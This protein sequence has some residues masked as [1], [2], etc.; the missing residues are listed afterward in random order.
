[1]RRVC[2]LKGHF[3]FC[4]IKY[5]CLRCSKSEDGNG[6]TCFDPKHPDIL[7]RLPD[8]VQ[9]QMPVILSTNG[10]IDRDMMELINYDVTHGQ[11]FQTSAERI[12][13]SLYRQHAQNQL[14]YL[15][16]HAS[17]QQPGQQT[18]LD[19]GHPPTQPP[20]QFEQLGS[21]GFAKPYIPSPQYLSS[22]WLEAVK[23]QVKWAEQ[24][25]SAGTGKFLCLDHTF[26]VAKYVR[27]ADGK[28]AHKCVL[29]VYNER[30][31][32]LGQYFTH[33]TS[34]LEVEDALR[35]IAARYKD[36]DGPEVHVPAMIHI[37]SL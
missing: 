13:T 12:A 20:P 18:R 16:L 22:A 14:S 32:V 36:G 4:G 17:K 3:Y 28:Q 26:R 37:I 5:K 30:A 9:S 8:W 2:G 7:A 24:H 35:K 15:Q 10:A 25:V 6:S 19:A 33:T 11:G 31:K 27:R 21:K 1:M 23:D 34:M 29:T